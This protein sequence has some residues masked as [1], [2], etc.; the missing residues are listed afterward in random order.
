[1]FGSVARVRTQKNRGDHELE[2]SYS[3]TFHFHLI[4]LNHKNIENNGL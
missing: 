3:S 4:A 1:M 2:L